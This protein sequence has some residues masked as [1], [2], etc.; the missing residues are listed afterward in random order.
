MWSPQWSN[1]F[2]RSIVYTPSFQNLFN[3]NETPC[4][5]LTLV[6]STILCYQLFST[7]F[8]DMVFLHMPCY[9]L[10]LLDC[11]GKEKRRRP[12]LA[13]RISGAGWPGTR[14]FHY[15]FILLKLTK[16]SVLQKRH[17]LLQLLT[18]FILF[19]SFVFSWPQ[20]VVVWVYFFISWLIGLVFGCLS[21]FVL[22][23]N[24]PDNTQLVNLY[25][26]KRHLLQ[27]A[28]WRSHHH[29]LLPCK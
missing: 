7:C 28:R 10:E 26:P 5:S 8:L 4:F 22:W 17:T 14:V 24:N 12:C 13:K 27:R 23:C 16:L 21:A 25:G 9:S 20:I 11:L 3:C 2:V 15:P 6:R 19:G 18:M 1:I 29:I